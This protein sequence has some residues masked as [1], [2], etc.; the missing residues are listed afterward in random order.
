MRQIGMLSL[1]GLC[2]L[3]S[4][5]G[6]G[7]AAPRAAT[8]PSAIAA[9]ANAPAAAA[10]DA[11]QAG[12]SVSSPPA[13]TLAQQPPPAPP[14]S[15]AAKPAARPEAAAEQA[16]RAV[17]KAAPAAGAI[18]VPLP[19]PAGTEQYTD[20]GVNGFVDPTEDRLST[21]AVDVDTASYSI[22]R[23][24]LRSGTLPPFASVRAEEFLN[25]F[26]Y[27][28]A[29]PTHA[30]F[31]VHLDAAPSPYDAGHH[32]V[33]I[34]LQAKRVSAA[35]RTPA[36]LV[37]LVDTSGSMQSPGKIGLAKQSLRMLT[38]QLR[39]GDT[40]ALC[41]YAGSVREVLP[42]T[43]GSER[44]RILAAI[45]SL[46]ASGSTAMSSGIDLAYNLARRTLVRGHINRVVVLSDGDANVGPAS[47]QEILERIGHY[48]DLGITLS[49]VGFGRGNYKDTMMEQLAN[50]GDGNY[51][52][53]DTQEQARR[54][55]VEQ[56]TGMLQVVARD[57]KVQV[58]FDPAAVAEYRLIGYE[59]RDVRDRDFRN[60]QV[61]AGE[62]GAG[63]NVTAV[64]DV[65]L[66]Q[67]R[68]RMRPPLIVR[69]RYQKPLGSEP[70]RELAVPL[71]G[72]RM[73]PS[74]D[75]AP[76]NLRFATAVAGFAEI[77]RRSPHA[78]S[79]SFDTVA[80]LAA[81]AAWGRKDQTELLGLIASARRLSG[82]GATPVAAIAE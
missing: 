26:D 65:V 34:G 2:A 40:V 70:A 62:I 55:F 44:E 76:A 20:Y 1:A 29:A 35:A 7:A 39:P 56:L 32:I 38:R 61:D 19:E 67:G 66:R 80:Q 5:W 23:S 17:G 75:A 11:A 51:Y 58:E 3:G 50:Q 37:Y 79:W 63:H 45:D 18:A 15:P 54:V 49:T 82:D 12:P 74:F 28:Y 43:G 27:G 48:K 78:R 69:L 24:K 53:I 73:H 42:P 41:T 71:T 72:S 21:F 68:D 10:V 22:A 59:N 36:H 81:E 13:P 52:Y 64:Y 4:T 33:R 14:A 46:S 30:P 6:C 9:E 25:Y 60:D 57:V 47:H 8:E 77:L 16:H 31:A